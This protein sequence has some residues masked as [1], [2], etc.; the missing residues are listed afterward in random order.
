MP[1]PLVVHHR[2]ATFEVYVARPG[3]W[4]NPYQMGVDGSRE[5][6]IA[7]YRAWLLSQPK[8][9]AAAKAELKGKVLGCFCA[10]LACH[11]D[12]LA[13]VANAT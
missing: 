4:G 13:E 11:G 3:K 8:M 10:P 5:E 2:R 9:V 7:K 1:H 12:V 6:V